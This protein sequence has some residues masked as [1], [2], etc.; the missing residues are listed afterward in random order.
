MRVNVNT[1][2][3]SDRIL[4]ADLGLECGRHRERPDA[5]KHVEQDV[6]IGQKIDDP[7]GPML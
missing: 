3:Y 4:L 7:L 5:G 2:P 1:E 6:L